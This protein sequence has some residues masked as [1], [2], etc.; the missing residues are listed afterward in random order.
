MRSHG[1]IDA[2]R[3]A[4]AIVRVQK[5]AELGPRHDGTGR[6]VKNFRGSWRERHDIRGCIPDPIAEPR[7]IERE[8]QAFG[9]RMAGSHR[10]ETIGHQAV[11]VDL[12]QRG[13]GR[14]QACSFASARSIAWY[15]ISRPIGLATKSTA[16]YLRICTTV[17]IS[18]APET[19]TTTVAGHRSRISFANQTPSR[20]GMITSENTICAG[21]VVISA[22]A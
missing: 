1:L 9:V 3:H 7:R 11:D 22:S 15:S 5:C 13:T 10:R 20:M 16:P 17:S 18:C 19:A 6:D 2:G 8:L 12:T 14:A 4:L 21:E